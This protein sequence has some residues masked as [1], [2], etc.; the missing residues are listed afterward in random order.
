MKPS[1]MPKKK[2]GINLFRLGK[3]PQNEHIYVFKSSKSNQCL[4]LWY[5]RPKKLWHWSEMDYVPERGSFQFNG[6]THHQ[7]QIKTH[8]ITKLLNMDFPNMAPFELGDM[9]RY[10][11]TRRDKYIA[12]EYVQPTVDKTRFRMLV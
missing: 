11:V 5:N 1:S 4:V 8:E 12:K 2:W 10:R 6:T 7:G 3:T 9:R